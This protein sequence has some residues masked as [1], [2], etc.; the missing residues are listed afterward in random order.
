MSANIFFT[1]RGAYQTPRTIR[2][3]NVSVTLGVGIWFSMSSML[4]DDLFFFWSFRSLEPNMDSCKEFWAWFSILGR[5]GLW[6]DICVYIQT[7]VATLAILNTG[8]IYLPPYISS[9]HK[10]PTTQYIAQSLKSQITKSTF[11]SIPSCDNGD[12]S[13]LLISNLEVH[14]RALDHICGI[15]RNFSEMI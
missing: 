1:A 8:Y 13:K 2:N 15:I 14:R 11:P 6:C 12:S 10:Q 5:N 9:P 4:T 3:G 7:K